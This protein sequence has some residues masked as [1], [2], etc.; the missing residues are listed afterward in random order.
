MIY[1]CSLSIFSS[2]SLSHKIS[3][4]NGGVATNADSTVWK[5]AVIYL[6]MGGRSPILKSLLRLPMRV[7]D[8]GG[9]SCV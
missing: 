9:D 4:G 2:A 7:T 6:Q 1:N 8:R 3:Y 5:D